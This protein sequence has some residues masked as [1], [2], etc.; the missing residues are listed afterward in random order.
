MK[1]NIL[2][3]FLTIIAFLFS[4]TASFSQFNDEI[5]CF[6]ILAGKNSNE[7]K[8]VL[9]AHNEDDWGDLLVNWYKVPA[10]DHNTG[11]KITFQ[12]GATIPQVKHTY[13]Y[14]WI[15]MPGMKFSDSYMNEWGLTV[16]SDQCKSREDKAETENG[17]IGYYLRRLMIERAKTAKEAVKIAG[18]LVETYGYN[19]SGRSYC[20]ADPNEAWI[21]AVVKGKHWIAQRIPDD[22]IAVIA[23]C[24]TIDK[25][26]LS[27]T[28]NFLGSEDII[29]YAVKRGWYDPGSGKEFSFKF[30]YSEPGIVNAIWNKPRAMAAINMLAEE[31]IAFGSNFPFSFVPKQGITK[32]DIMKVLASHLE[33]TDFESCSNKNPHFNTASRVCSPGNQYG[34]VAE[35]RDDLPKE[36]ANIMWIAIK[37]P[38]IQPFIPWYFGITDIPEEFTYKNWKIALQDHFSQKDLKSKTKDK[39]Y[40]SYKELADLTDNNYFELTGLIKNKKKLTENNLLRNQSKF[41]KG[42]MD[43]YKNDKNKAIKYLNLFENKII[44]ENLAD[45]R[46]ALEL[47]K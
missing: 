3:S 20:I 4:L 22:E 46:H 44:N 41:E 24:Y 10:Q 27:D 15:E 5:E 25:I 23:N 2:L 31:K 19:Y 30:A 13:S 7:D 26:N 32:Q 8:N 36:I 34:F 47:L 17:G 29:D 33:G 14:L 38:C 11:E 12:H 21:M 42:F 6:S 35:L 18:K 45:T 40:W 9:L 37:R 43:L 1:K 16:A 39:A 28:T